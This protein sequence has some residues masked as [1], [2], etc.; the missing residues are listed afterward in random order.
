MSKEDF[1]KLIKT[2]KYWEQNWPTPEQRKRWDK[3]FAEID[4]DDYERELRYVGINWAPEY[5][6]KEKRFKPTP[7]V[8]RRRQADRTTR[9]P[10]RL[11]TK[12]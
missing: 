1:D 4:P 2:A 10:S 9:N 7:L 12:A 3:L 6:P 8:P 5:L 11:V